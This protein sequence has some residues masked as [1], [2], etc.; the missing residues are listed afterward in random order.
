MKPYLSTILGIA[1]PLAVVAVS[2][3]CSSSSNNTVTDG[4][5]DAG[6]DSGPPP[7]VDTGPPPC[8]DSQC[9]TGNKCLPDAMGNVQ[10]QL[11]CNLQ[12]QQPPQPGQPSEPCPFNY[13]CTDFPAGTPAG[14]ADRAFCTPDK[15][16]YKAPATLPDGGTPGLWGAP[17]EPTGGIET[18][19]ACDSSQGFWCYARSPTDGE[20]YCTQ[21]QCTADT[22][23]RGGW[24]CATQN[25]EPN[26]SSNGRLSTG[27]TIRV[28]QPRNYCST[29]LSDVDCDGS[30]SMAGIKE[31][32][33]ADRNG[34]S[35]CA[36][37]CIVG[38]T[39]L[40]TD[41]QCITLDQSGFCGKKD[42]DGGVETCVCAADAREC[43]GDGKLCAPCLSDADCTAT[44]GGLCFT[45]DY[46][47]EH[48][49]AI[50]T[51]GACPTSAPPTTQCPMTDEAPNS[52]SIA[53]LTVNDNYDLPNYCV[54]IVMLDGEPNV[55]CWTPSR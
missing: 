49:C 7:P 14:S 33:I 29:C 25:L 30:G 45:A 9:Y 37:E 46:S 32:C 47:T 36:P 17:C 5:T 38:S 51:D 27:A 23:C 22:D 12:Y 28:C 40:N 44:K 54:G 52:P 20:A 15:N 48:F 50:P 6:H 21:F 26:A 1:L 34:T 10:C 39:C 11:P 35:Y 16:Q 42:A 31:H 8:V 19:P 3:A 4:G 43:T 18:N 41:A 13:T 55:G 53:C 24:W 2:A